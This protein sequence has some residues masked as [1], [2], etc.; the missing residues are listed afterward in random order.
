VLSRYESAEEAAKALVHA[1]KF[2]GGEKLPAPQEGWGDDEYNVLWEAL[3]R[4]ETPDGYD[5]SGFEP[6]E[7][8]PWDSGLLESMVNRLHAAGLTQQQV[9]AVV[10]GYGEEIGNQYGVFVQ[11]TAAAQERATKE[12][13]QKWG[14]AYAAKLESATRAFHMAGGER[15]KELAE[16]RLD[17]GTQLGNHPAFIEAFASLGDRMAEHGVEGAKNVRLSST[18]DEAIQKRSELE[19]DKGFMEAYLTKSHPQHE[20][21]VEK[22]RALEA[23]IHGTDPV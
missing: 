5:L 10:E 15:A 2:I 22:I 21:A 8:V 1:Q 16:M 14:S 11:E 9:R 3:G 12:L 7:G 4:P 19:A 20:Q 23:A 18:P 13:Q 17:D 6:P